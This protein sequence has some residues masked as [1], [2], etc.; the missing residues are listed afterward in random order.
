MVTVRPTP[1]PIPMDTHIRYVDSNLPLNI[2]VNTSE[3]ALDGNGTCKEPYPR[4]ENLVKI[5]IS[6]TAIIF[7]LAFAGNS[8]VLLVLALRK[9]KLSRMHMFIMHL[10]LADLFVAFFNV[11]PQMA[12][13]VTYRFQGGDFLCR[14]VKYVQVVAMYASSYVLVATALD[15]YTAIVYPLTTHTW[16]QRRIAL[17][18]GAAWLLSLVFSVPQPIMFSIQEV[19]ANM[20]CPVYDCWMDEHDP[21][22]IQA[23]VTV[24]LMLVYFLPLL[25][26]IFSY[27]RI[28]CIVWHSMG[29]RETPSPSARPN[30]PHILSKEA[31]KGL[32]MQYEEKLL[33]K[34]E[35]APRAHS[36]GISNAKMKTIKL[37]MAVILCYQIC[38]S[39][40]FV[41][42]MY[43]AWDPAPLYSGESTSSTDD[44]GHQLSQNN[45]SIAADFMTITVL[46]ASLNSMTNPWIF[47][48][49]N[50]NI[51]QQVKARYRPSPT[52]ASASYFTSEYRTS[53]TKIGAS[54]AHPDTAT[55]N[56]SSPRDRTQYT[57]S[58]P[59]KNMNQKYSKATDNGE[60]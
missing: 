42:Q 36:R 40:F 10:S 12:W 14:F 51:C 49:F 1:F 47:L 33:R 54:V 9:K 11:L 39:P 37:T 52:T 6:V 3:D 31:T 17:M 24:F 19:K 58:I 4:D 56:D 41:S 26:L 28:C 45:T 50:D 20:T 8:I 43:W 7:I 48:L 30:T 25:V 38:W 34:N 2:S 60:M 5:E 21:D 59:M 15:R 23:Y 13:D 16:S 55:L 57:N 18:V 27:G 46:L 32:T 22:Y 44:S 35:S 29:A 53:S